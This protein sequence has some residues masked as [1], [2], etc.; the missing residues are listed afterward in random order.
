MEEKGDGSLEEVVYKRNATEYVE[1]SEGSTAWKGN[2]DEIEGTRG[3]GLPDGFE[4]HNSHSDTNVVAV[5]RKAVLDPV[6]YDNNSKAGSEEGDKF[7]AGRVVIDGQYL[8]F[9]LDVTDKTVNGYPALGYRAQVES[10]DQGIYPTQNGTKFWVSASGGLVVFED[11]VYMD[12]PETSAKSKPLPVNITCFEYTGTK[13]SAILETQETGIEGL[14]TDLGTNDVGGEDAFTRIR[15]LEQGGSG[16]IEYLVCYEGQ[17]EPSASDH[18]KAILLKQDTAAGAETPDNTFTEYISVQKTQDGAWVWEK[19]GESGLDLEKVKGLVSAEAER[20]TGAEGVLQGKIDGLDGRLGTAEGY[21]SSFTKSFNTIGPKIDALEADVELIQ[22]HEKTLFGY[23]PVIDEVRASVFVFGPRIDILE[24][25]LA[26]EI[27]RAGESEADL[28]SAIADEVSR[29][30]GKESELSGAIAAEESRAKGAEGTLDTAIKGEKTRAE[31]AEEDLESAIEA[32]VVRATTE[33]GNLSNAIASE[34]SRATNAENGLRDDLGTNDEPDTTAFGRIKATEALVGTRNDPEDIAIETTASVFGALKYLKN[35]LPAFKY[36]ILKSTESLP[37]LDQHPEYQRTLALQHKGEDETEKNIFTEYLSVQDTTGATPVWRWEKLGESGLDLSDLENLK[38]LVGTADDTA[39]LD[40][41]LFARLKY[42]IQRATGAEETLQGSISNEAKTRASE[43]TRILTAAKTYVDGLTVF[44]YG[45]RIDALEESVDEIEPRVVT[46]E[47]QMSEIYN[48][49]FT[50]G[51]RITNLETSVNTLGPTVIKLKEDLG[52]RGDGQGDAFTR[53]AALES[54]STGHVGYLVHYDKSLPW[55]SA[56]EHKQ[57]ILLVKDA[58]SSEEDDNTFTE[59]I[60]VQSVSGGTWV[61]EKVGESGLDLKNI[62]TKDYA[63][64]MRDAAIEASQVTAYNLN[65]G[66]TTGT[67]MKNMKVSGGYVAMV[68]DPVTNEVTLYI[69]ENKDNGVIEGVEHKGAE[70][71]N[72]RYVYGP[73]SG[74]SFALPSTVTSGG[75]YKPCIKWDSAAGTLLKVAVLPEDVLAEKTDTVVKAT[76][77]VPGSTDRS[78][79]HNAGQITGSDTGTIQITATNVDIIDRAHHQDDYEEIINAGGKTPGSVQINGLAAAFDIKSLLPNLGAAEFK[80]SIGGREF[81]TGELFFY[82]TK[83]T[84]EITT[85]TASFDASNIVDRYVSGYKY[86]GQGTKV[87]TSA[88]ANNTCHYVAD[89]AAR[90]KVDASSVGAGSKSWTPSNPN[91]GTVV[92][93]N[94]AFVVGPNVKFVANPTVTVSAYRQTNSNPVT[95]SPTIGG[96]PS[97]YEGVYSYKGAPTAVKEDFYGENDA[98][99]PDWQR[100]TTGKGTWNSETAL[101]ADNPG[102]KVCNGALSYPE[103]QSGTRSYCRWFKGTADAYMQG[104]QITVAGLEGN[105]KN[106][107]V[108]IS[109]LDAAGRKFQINRIGNAPDGTQGIS[110]DTAP[111]SSGHWTCEFPSNAE[112][113]KINAGI[114]VIVE[115][116][117][118]GL[119]LGTITF[120]F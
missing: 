47:D 26:S 45:P 89:Q 61:W 18:P 94:T 15:A 58:E 57:S 24:D 97:G 40:G 11:A 109:C 52:E 90:L 51:P 41:S 60:S 30:T 112:Q 73:S 48:S 25:G 91:I 34:A 102:L 62:A 65:Q 2:W 116:N 50:Y 55:P 36:I 87:N 71:A 27:Q 9:F 96:K 117:G 115:M 80:V 104:F 100:K 99:N 119:N 3:H 8:P 4:F 46:L 77:T 14:R 105:F 6:T 13:L 16:H 19:V 75:K 98:T 17:A 38:G 81:S 53:I 86:I 72:S 107:R 1:Y 92:S 106:D 22:E 64:D 88:A 82:D 108:T 56:S 44:A 31:K 93:G 103:G 84:P 78:A 68:T 39:D 66:D 79:S 113:P 118:T 29:A 35:H 20:A 101:S 83:A 59:Y 32:E 54:G 111:N 33:E 7:H 74:V 114:F 120:E 70:D 5:L 76:I 12:D 95:S 21:I 67:V 63:E 69:R 49:V 23:G 10:G 42:E 110:K 28:G 43:D 37:D 85:A